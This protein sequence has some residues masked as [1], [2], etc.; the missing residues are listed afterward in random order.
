MSLSFITQKKIMVIE[1]DSGRINSILLSW[2]RRR[3][4]RRGTESEDKAE[5]ESEMLSQLSELSA[6]G[7][8]LKME[9]IDRQTDTSQSKTRL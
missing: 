3:R 4:S 7:L 5:T 1:L 9:T 6:D 8:R 2:R